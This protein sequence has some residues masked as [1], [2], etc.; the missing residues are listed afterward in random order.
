VTLNSVSYGAVELKRYAQLYWL[1]GLGL[2]IALHF[3]IIA[4]FYVFGLDACAGEFTLPPT[5]FTPRFVPPP[6]TPPLP[7][8]V[9]PSHPIA[10]PHTGTAGR[11]VPVPE[12]RV[13]PDEVFPTQAELRARVAPTD[14]SAGTG[15]GEGPIVIPPSEEEAPPEWVQ[16]EELPHVVK[17]VVPVYPELALRAGLTGRVFVKVWVDKEGRVRKALAMGEGNEIFHQPAVDAAMQ[18]VFT[19]AIMNGRPVSVWVSIPF[20]FTLK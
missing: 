20:A 17:R 11:L 10:P 5:V 2:A 16:T 9:E 19:P 13:N 18:F 4:S 14:A 3:S 6:T 1:A 12:G 8:I 15:S 7:G